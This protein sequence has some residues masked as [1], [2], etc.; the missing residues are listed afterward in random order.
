MSG[1]APH[2]TGGG[3]SGGDSRTPFPSRSS[4]TTSRLST[5]GRGGAE[6]GAG[7]AAPPEGAPAP[8]LSPFLNNMLRFT[9]KNNP[10][11][12]QHPTHLSPLNRSGRDSVTNA[13]QPQRRAWFAFDASNSKPQQQQQARNNNNNND[14]SLDPSSSTVMDATS[15][16]SSKN[17]NSNNSTAVL[18]DGIPVDHLRALAQHSLRTAPA[19]AAFYAGLLCAKTGYAEDALLLAQTHL[20]AGHTEACLRTLEEA[21]LLL[22]QH[23]DYYPWEA[24]LLACQALEAKKDWNALIE[25]LE[26]I[27]RLPDHN[28]M[29]GSSSNAV[30]GGINSF[31]SIAASQP[32]EDDDK[33][34]WHS[35]KRT[36]PHASASTIHPLALVCWYR[37]LAYHETDS[38]IRATTYW[39]LAL[40]MDCQCQAAWEALLDKNLLTP[41][42]AHRLVAN[43]VEF[44]EDQDWL[45]SLYLAR[46]ELTPQEP[47]EDTTATTTAAAKANKQTPG[48]SSGGISMAL[49]GTSLDASSIQMS[50]PIPSFQTPGGLRNSSL[51]PATIGGGTRR[52]MVPPLIQQDVDAAFD[53]LWNKHKLQDSPQVLAMAARR[54]YRRY[55]WKSALAYCQEL[56]QLDPAVEQVV[57]CYVATLVI[58]GHKRVLFR[59]AHE[60]VEASPKA[61]HAWFAVGAYYYCIQRYHV[62]QRHFCRATRLDPQCTEAWIAFGC[63]FA[64]C[65]ESDQAL[66]SFR[67]AQRLSPGEHTSLMYM[68]MEY[69]RTNHLVLAEYFLQAALKA[70]GGDP[71]CLHERGVLAAQK[72]EHKEAITW[73]RRALT[74]A[75]GAGETS[76]LQESIDL[77]HDAYWEPTIFNLGHSYRKMRQFEQAALCFGRCVSL[78]PDKFSTYSALAFTEHLMG[79]FDSAIAHY[80]EALGIKPDDPFSTD[81]LNRALNEQ[82][83]SRPQKIFDDELLPLSTTASKKAATSML[84]SPGASSMWSPREDSAMSEDSVSDV[85]MSAAS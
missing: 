38:G 55:D 30:P 50:S 26:D 35:L 54:A 64:A 13:G 70:S 44:A 33:I 20:A 80:H 4:S 62:A 46:I 76:L 43:D 72:D 59:L 3:G 45:R 14:T 85:D 21:A 8:Q 75:V 29:G 56:A 73:F 19:T 77:C 49:Q 58:L 18:V 25:L 34:G 5:G 24:V 6:A 7:A 53:N 41:A 10:Q 42:D 83:M 63:S 52:K 82:T 12:Q 1:G 9:P 47:E 68:G 28:N 36:I 61:A 23:P 78:C 74:S 39:K 67:A 79:D 65:D 57:Y 71:L 16:T 32:I 51:A 11:S 48:L 27:C 40:K 60:W 69:V 81:L 31:H 22:P 37:G 84:L 17:T 2:G 66:A 15:S